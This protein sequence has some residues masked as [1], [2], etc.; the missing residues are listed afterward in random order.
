MAARPFRFREKSSVP[1]P[2]PSALLEHGRLAERSPAINAPH[3]RTRLKWI[4]GL[5]PIAQLILPLMLDHPFVHQLA[6]VAG[7]VPV[8]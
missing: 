7:V 2:Y 6:E 4:V 1:Q 3:S 5:I 8:V